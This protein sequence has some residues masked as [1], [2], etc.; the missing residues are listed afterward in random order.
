MKTLLII[1]VLIVVSLMIIEK[2]EGCE[3][4]TVT[5]Y[6]DLET[7]TNCITASGDKPF[8]GGIACPRN[9]PLGKKVMI[10]GTIFQCSDRTNLRYNGRYDI[11]FGMGIDAYNKAIIFGKRKMLVCL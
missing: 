8:I 2:V 1:I 11:F 4:A 9:I 10:N 5:A 3:I 6:T 7:C